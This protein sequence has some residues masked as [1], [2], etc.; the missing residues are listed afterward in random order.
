[1][2]LRER[3]RHPR[4]Q[5]R[6]WIFAAC[7][8]DF[9]KL[10][11]VMDISGGGIAIEYVSFSGGNGNQVGDTAHLEVFECGSSW[12]LNHTACRIVYDME[13]PLGDSILHNYQ[14]RRCALRF[15]ELSRER[16]SQLDS[17]I[18]DFRAV[19]A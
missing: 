7:R 11:K 6:D 10:G 18:K 3:R 5:I 2:E 13:V 16:A 19:P 8:A 4:F 17:F 14:I 1:V 15:G 9:L 12:C